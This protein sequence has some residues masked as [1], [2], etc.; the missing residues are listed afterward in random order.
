MKSIS[1]IYKIMNNI[2]GEFYIGSSVN[3]NRRISAHTC[4]LNKGKHRN[5]HLQNA[6]MSI[7]R[8][9]LKE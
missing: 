8:Y 5:K 6:V 3:L 2:N 9:C 4:D 1:A 7:K